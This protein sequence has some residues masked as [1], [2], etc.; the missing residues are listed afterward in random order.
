MGRAGTM[1]L[2]P[3]QG[4]LIE[5]RMKALRANV[6]VVVVLLSPILAAYAS[7]GYNW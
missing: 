5:R 2:L 3:Q 6:T 4:Q 1:R 7:A